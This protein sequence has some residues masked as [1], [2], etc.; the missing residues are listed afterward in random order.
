[1]KSPSAINQR[2]APAKR[3]FHGLSG[4]PLAEVIPFPEPE[5]QPAPAPKRGRPRK[6][7]DNA[8]KQ[9]AHRERKASEKF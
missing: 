4:S 3:A 7:P 6:H 9:K 5:Q 1:M 2:R 8:S